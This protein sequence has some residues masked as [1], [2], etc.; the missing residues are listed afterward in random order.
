M[1]SPMLRLA[2]LALA[3]TLGCYE[4]HP[5]D[6]EARPDAAGR[7]GGGG[8]IDG[9]ALDAGGGID[10]GGERDGGRDAAVDPG[11]D[12]GGD[13]GVDGGMDAGVDAGMD[14]GMDAGLV[15]CASPLRAH[16]SWKQASAMFDSTS[17]A[18]DGARLSSVN[19]LF[20]L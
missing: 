17:A 18:T 4:F 12:A 13:P 6:P 9:G 10:G 7:D 11:F 5:V 16:S 20:C 15:E 2:S 1:V 14:A 8:G 3:L 19:S